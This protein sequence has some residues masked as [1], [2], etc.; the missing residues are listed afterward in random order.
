MSSGMSIRAR[1]ALAALAAAACVPVALA[2]TPAFTMGWSVGGG[3]TETYDWSV[4]GSLNG[5]DDWTVPGNKNIWTGWNYTGVLVGSTQTGTWQIDWNCVF[6]DA[7]EGGAGGGNAFVT[8]NIVVTNNDA[9]IQNFSLLMTLPTGLLGTVTEQGSLVGTV[10]DLNFGDATVFAP[11]GGRIY[12]PM[13]DGSDEMPGFLMD[14]PFSE[15][16]GGPGFS[17]IVGP[18]DFGIPAPVAA[19]QTVDSSIGILL[20]FD[21]TGNDAASFTAIFQVLIPAPAGLPI[22]AAV[23][24]VAGRRRRRQ[25][26]G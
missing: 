21:L 23:G 25:A 7:V 6:N 20:D 12:T 22:L 14:D 19:T 8:A 3:P 17:G 2:Q 13:I 18:A 11:A 4:H 24:L 26:R 9:A 5:Y 1:P 16:A 15:S 10:T